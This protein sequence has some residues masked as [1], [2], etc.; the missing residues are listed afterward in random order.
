MSVDN[1]HGLAAIKLG[2][3]M[4]GGLTESSLNL[5]VETQKDATSGEAFARYVSVT[6]GKPA[7]SFTTKGLH[8]LLN[9]VGVRGAKLAAVLYAQAFAE[10]G[11]RAAGNAHRSFTGAVAMIVPRSLS[12]AHKGDATITYDVI[13]YSA[14]GATDPVVI[15][16]AVAI[17]ALAV[18][19][20]EQERYTLGPV[21]VAGVTLGQVQSV[22]ID[23]GINLVIEGADSDLYGT[24]AR[25]P[26]IDPT[27]TIVGTDLEWL[28][29]TAGTT[30]DI[31]Q[32]GAAA[33]HADTQIFFRKRITGGSFEVDTAAVHPNITMHGLARP[34]NSFS[35]SGQDKSN[36]GIIVE[37]H[38]DGTNDPLVVTPAAAIA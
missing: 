9:V 21:M 34:Q 35:A 22:E 12:V 32:K 29:N 25:I 31:P 1:L 13:I 6:G 18:P 20:W 17:P 10:G 28:Q 26:S 38:Y 37:A 7:A 8:R 24:F 23:F 15:A 5:N 19:A 11:T 4:Y 2:A 14:D 27:I 36:C 16:D 30:G 3:V 33:V